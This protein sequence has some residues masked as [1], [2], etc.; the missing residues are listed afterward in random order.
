MTSLLTSFGH[1]LTTNGFLLR[2]RV[3]ALIVTL[4]WQARPAVAE[5]MEPVDDATT[6]VVEASEKTDETEKPESFALISSRNIFD[7]DRSAP[8]TKTEPPPEKAR[9]PVVDTIGLTGI[10]TYSKGTFAFFDGS[11]S[12]YREAVKSG[13]TFAGYSVRAISA[14]QVELKKDDQSI[15]LKIGEQLRREDAGEWKITSNAD[16]SRPSSIEKTASVE[17]ASSASVPSSSSEPSDALKRLLE[18]RKNE[19][20]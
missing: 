5:D 6:A 1:S 11:S 10:M 12:L 20:K 17:S 19:L 14:N 3:F 8:R 13:D 16:F 18:K 9:V 4:M 15:E 7:P 2:L